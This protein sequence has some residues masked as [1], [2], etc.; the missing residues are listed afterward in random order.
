MWMKIQFFA[1]FIG[2][3][4]ECTRGFTFIIRICGAMGLLSG[5]GL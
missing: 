4:G 2:I 3:A 5:I 1:S